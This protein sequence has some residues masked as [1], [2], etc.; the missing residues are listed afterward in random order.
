[1]PVF[2]YQDDIR[3]LKKMLDNYP[4]IALGGLVGS[5]RYRLQIWLDGI[6][7]KHLSHKDGTPR[8]KVHGFGLTDFDLMKRYP[9]FSIDSSSWLLAGSFGG[10]VFYEKG[11]LFKIV[12]SADNPA[13]RDFD[14]RHYD[15]LN[16]IEKL[17]VDKWLKPHGVT[18]QQCA[19]H[20]RFRHLV[21]AAT[22]QNLETIGIKKLRVFTH[23]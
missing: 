6:W 14:G 1:M 20:F 9:W 12:F 3:Y 11:R 17:E 8:V 7:Y 18:A 23:C 5:H 15:R 16:A 13:R 4:F 19:S 22:Y 21:N 2:H 10:C